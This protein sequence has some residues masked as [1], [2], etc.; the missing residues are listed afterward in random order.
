MAF[1]EMG[2]LEGAVDLPTSL[3]IVCQAL[4]QEWVKSMDS[5]ISVQR[6]IATLLV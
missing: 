3:L 6:S 2:H 1:V 5:T 4:R